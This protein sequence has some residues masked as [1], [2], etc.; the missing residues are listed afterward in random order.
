MWK[1]SSWVF[2][3]EW[4]KVMVFEFRDGE[5]AADDEDIPPWFGDGMAVN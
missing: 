4:E 1:D 3:E 5:R 2:G